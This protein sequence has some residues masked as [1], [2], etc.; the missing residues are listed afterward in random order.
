MAWLKA[1]SLITVIGGDWKT[2]CP[3]QETAILQLRR[4]KMNHLQWGTAP[5]SGPVSCALTRRMA[6]ATSRPALPSKPRA[7]PQG[8]SHESFA[9]WPQAK[10]Q[11]CKARTVMQRA[12]FR[13][14][15]TEQH[16]QDAFLHPPRRDIGDLHSRNEQP[17]FPP[18]W[19]PTT[20]R[21]PLGW[22]LDHT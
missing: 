9:A 8:G 15:G 1:P 13:A 17:S 20:P 2:K 6:E 10:A 12:T 4:H 16:R 5:A 22:P 18:H 11:T 19:Q 21:G 3:E 14:C 7:L